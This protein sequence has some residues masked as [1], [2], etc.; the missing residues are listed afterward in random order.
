MPNCDFWAF[1]D[2]HRVILDYIF[3]AGEC[4]VFESYSV[5]DQEL[6]EFRSLIDFQDRFRIE[7]W[8]DGPSETMLLQL[9]PNG[10][11]GKFMI[12]RFALDP[13]KCNGA[14][15]RYRCE[16]WGLVQLYL[17]APYRNVLRESHTNHNSDKRAAAW[18]ATYPEFGPASDW[19][20]QV[21]TSFSRHLNR[22][23]HK[24]AVDKIGSR[25]VLPNAKRFL[26][27]TGKL[28]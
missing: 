24:V 25:V 1:G 3:A 2:D 10:A 26:A 7:S 27:S 9:Y 11:C 21:L 20:W 12:N 17:E 28:V 19:N 14:T 6:V 13:R 16:G 8:D 18:E 15:F 22:F 4:R 5:P 23:I